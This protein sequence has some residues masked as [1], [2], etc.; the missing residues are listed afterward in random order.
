MSI[1]CS[2]LSTNSPKNPS[3]SPRTNQPTLP[4]SVTIIQAIDSRDSAIFQDQL[5]LEFIRAEVEK[6]V[7]NG[8][9]K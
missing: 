7:I 5:V 1:N 4:V 3:M 2:R 8:G 9:Q 6:P